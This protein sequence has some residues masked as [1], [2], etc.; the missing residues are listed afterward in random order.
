[1][2]TLWTGAPEEDAQIKA[3]VAY[4]NSLGTEGALEAQASAN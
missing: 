4:L 3:I 2:P 1:M